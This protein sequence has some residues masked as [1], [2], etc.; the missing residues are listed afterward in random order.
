MTHCRLIDIPHF[1]AKGRRH[2]Y[3]IHKHVHVGLES[4]AVPRSRTF[5]LDPGFD[6]GVDGVYFGRRACDMRVSERIHVTVGVVN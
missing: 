2:E 4:S 5:K 3:I 6:A 1:I